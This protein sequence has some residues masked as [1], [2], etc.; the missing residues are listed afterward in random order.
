MTAPAA[1]ILVSVVD[2]VVCIKI[3]GRANFTSSV[4]FKTLIYEL[5][6]RGTR[7]FLIDL[8]ECVIMDSTF[9]G[10]MA[11]FGLKLAATGSGKTR[12]QVELLNPNP[13]VTD[14]LDNLGVSHLFTVRTGANPFSTPFEALKPDDA[15]QKVEVSRTCLEAHETLMKINPDNVPKFKDVARFLAEDLKR[16]ETTQV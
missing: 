4:G 10:V 7:E 13:R 12:C 3:T 6:Q 15:S 8:T 2:P 16:M 14:L 9:L 11:G 5:L 1:N